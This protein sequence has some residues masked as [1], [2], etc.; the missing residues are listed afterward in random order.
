MYNICLNH[1]R[2]T[3]FYFKKTIQNIIF[4]EY[5]QFSVY[6]SKETFVLCANFTLY[7]SLCDITLLEISKTYIACKQ[8][9]LN[10]GRIMS[11]LN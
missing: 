6:F 11:W 3:Q 9:N 1:W 8:N 7:W 10:Y 2:H 4:Y 5:L